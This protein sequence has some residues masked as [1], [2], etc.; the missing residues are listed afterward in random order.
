MPNVWYPMKN[1]RCL[2]RGRGLE[3]VTIEGEGPRCFLL[4]FRVASAQP[5][6]QATQA[7][8]ICPIVSPASSTFAA[9]TEEGPSASQCSRKGFAQAFSQQFGAQAGEATPAQITCLPT[10]SSQPQCH[11][12]IITQEKTQSQQLLYAESTP[13]VLPFPL[14]C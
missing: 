11:C 12:L 8:P 6:A 1:L 2:E 10:P 5:V 7:P 9:Q 3:D 4:R 14:E 13:D